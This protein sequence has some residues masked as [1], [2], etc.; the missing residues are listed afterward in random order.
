MNKGTFSEWGGYLPFELDFTKGEYF[1]DHPEE[2]IVRLDCGRSAFWYALNDAK[3]C[4]VYTPYLNCKNSTDPIEGLGIPYEYYELEDDLTPKGVDLKAGEAIIW[5]NY[6]GNAT[7]E[8]IEKI[9]HYGDDGTLIVDNCNAFWSKPLDNAYN[10][11]S[12]R[13]FFGVC[14]GAYLIKKNI[15]KIKLERSY[16][17]PHIQFIL[18]C[19]ERGTNACYQENLKNEE[20]L[21]KGCKAMSLLTERILNSIDYKAVKE[22][23]N[24]NFDRL[25]E[26]IGHMNEFRVNTESGT[27]MHYPLLITNDQ[28]RGWL[29]SRRLYTP[30]WWRHVPDYF[31]GRDTI[32][33][34]LS[35]YMLM[36]PID[37]RYEAK[38]MDAISELIH[39]GVEACQ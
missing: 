21:G 1:K 3:P 11:Y 16:S 10:C 15:D 26:L 27:Q 35:K 9:R 23:R 33:R 25:H 17:A 5:V 24:R 22:R 20:R 6:Y 38:D 18:D 4:K 14:D 7:R 37:Q 29:V 34:R 28:I 39:E 8:S 31:E 12:T 19:I 36:I 2:D 30:T 13:K 32:E